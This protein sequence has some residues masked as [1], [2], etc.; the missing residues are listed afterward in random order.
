[1]STQDKLSELRAD[2]HV[3]NIKVDPYCGCLSWRYDDAYESGFGSYPCD[4]HRNMR[5]L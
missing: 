3:S 1:M 5:T 2:P 4:Q